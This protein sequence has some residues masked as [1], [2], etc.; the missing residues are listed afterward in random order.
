L[1]G[2]R[3]IS[4]PTVRQPP[5][6]RIGKAR[7]RS[8]CGPTRPRRLERTDCAQIAVAAPRY[9]AKDCAVASRYL[10]RHQPEPGAGVAA[11]REGVASD[12]V[13]PMRSRSSMGSRDQ[14]RSARTN[15]GIFAPGWFNSLGHS[16][17]AARFVL[18]VGSIERLRAERRSACLRSCLGSAAPLGRDV[19]LGSNTSEKERPQCYAR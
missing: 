3:E 8:R 5:P 6:V 13:P 10:F 16:L 1:R 11:F 9:A 14:V 4:R 2:N 15:S 7:S 17:A 18:G 19:G 12:S